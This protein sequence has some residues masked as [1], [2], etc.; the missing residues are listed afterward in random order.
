MIA[1]FF[2]PVALSSSF[3][4]G[5]IAARIC[6]A[7]DATCSSSRGV[8]LAVVAD[9]GVADELADLL[10][11][12][13][14]DLRDELEEEPADELA[15]IL[16]RRE[17]LLLG[18]GCETAR[19]EVVVLVEALLLALGEERA[20]AGEALLEV[21]ELLV[22]VDVDLLGLRLDLVLEVVQVLR[23]RLVVDARDDRGGEVQD[24]LE[25][26]RGDVE[27]VA[28]A[29]RHALEEPDVR[30]RRGQVDVAHALATHLLARHL[31]AAALADDALVADALV[32]AAV[33]LP[34]LRRAEDALAEEAVALGLER[35][36]VDRLRLRDLARRPVADLL[37]RRETDADRVEL[38][39]V[40]QVT[41]RLISFRS[42][43]RSVFDFDVVVVGGAHGLGVLVVV[44]VRARSASRSC[45]D[46]SAGSTSS[47]SVSTRSWPSSTSWRREAAA[48][49]ARSEP[50]ERS[51]PSSSAARSSSSSSSRTSTS[52]PSSEM[53]RDVERQRLHLLQEHLERL[54]DRRLGDVLAL[55]DRLVRLDAPDRVVGLDREHLLQRVRGAVGLERPDLHLAEALAA[56]LRLAA[57]RLLGDERVR[58]R[59]T[60]VD[61]VVDEVEQLE[62]VHVADGHLLLERL[63]GAAAEQAHLARGLAAERSLRVGQDLDRAVG[64]LLRPEEQRRVDVLDRGAVEDGRRDRGAASAR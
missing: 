45:R 36:V 59:R 19:P 35:A 32:L 51:M 1:P 33:A 30:D 21:G 49:A 25:L 41:S 7:A 24:L 14:R 46:S 62:D 61:L 37:R 5:A 63:A 23:A 26:A 43:V 54:G 3:S 4:S 6:S 29:A 17:H 39:D 22:A 28:D 55:D 38:V 18:P 2:A 16:E 52:P 44:G 12:L 8:E 64:V 9:R 40:D 31:D 53:T 15:R 60:R 57:E 56:E 47:P 50:G 10:R 11:V 20:P 27:Q 34:V 48:A 58:A 13:G 42:S